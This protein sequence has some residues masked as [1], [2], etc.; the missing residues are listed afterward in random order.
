MISEQEDGVDAGGRKDVEK[1][2]V[3]TKLAAA[4]RVCK[5]RERCQRGDI[6]L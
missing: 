3:E 2:G 6:F 1:P 5:E 4:P